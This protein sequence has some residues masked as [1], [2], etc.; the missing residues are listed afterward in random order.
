MLIGKL[1]FFAYGTSQKQSANQQNQ[2]QNDVFHVKTIQSAESIS[3]IMQKM[4][5]GQKTDI[6]PFCTK[7]FNKQ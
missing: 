4:K 1:S 2:S 6:R 3:S 7:A 5:I